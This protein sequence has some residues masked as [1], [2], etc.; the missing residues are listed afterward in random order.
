MLL[1]YVAEIS[2]NFPLADIVLAGDVNQL[3]EQDIVE[4]TGLTQIVQ[5]PTR[6]GNILDCV[7]VSDPDI[8]GVVRVVASVLRSDHKAVVCL[9]D[10]Q[11]S[12]VLK[13]RERRSFRSHTPSQHATFL[14][15]AASIDFTNPFPTVSSNPAINTQAEFDHFYRVA[16]SLLDG[17]FPTQTVTV[18]SRD[19]G[20]ITPE[21]KAI[22]RRKN[23]LMRQGRV[24]KAGALAA[25]IGKKITAQSRLQLRGINARTDTKELWAAVRKLTKAGKSEIVV[26]GITAESL[27]AH[28]AATSTDSDYVE[29]K[30]RRQMGRDDNGAQLVADYVSEWQVFQL[31]DKLRPTAAGTDGL[32]AWYLK[33]GAPVF[34]GPLHNLSLIHI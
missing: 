1:D 34:S 16:L 25:R 10:R 27:N 33:L 12:T 30:H 8:F 11:S 4:R 28:Y 9:T 5:Q 32:P 23:R 7:F 2:H 15:T 31:L 18:T 14:Q 20:P 17:M 3:S 6:G 26:E 22:L 13:T 19:P 29:P 24:E 21:I